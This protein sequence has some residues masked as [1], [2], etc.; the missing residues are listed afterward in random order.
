MPLR[1]KT[2][3]YKG[4]SMA[5][6]FRFGDRLIVEHSSVTD[7][8]PGD[9]VIYRAL[10]HGGKEK[11]L[12]HRVMRMLPKG[13]VARG[14][15]NPFPDR[16]LVTESNLEGRVSHAER[17]GKRIPVRGGWPGLVWAFKGHYFRGI[18][19]WAWGIICHIGRMLY[20]RLRGSGLVAYLW[21]PSVERIRLLTKQGRVVKYVYRNRT[22][23]CYFPQNGRFGC[24][25]PYDL[26]LWHEVKTMGRGAEAKRHPV[27]PLQ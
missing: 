9:V 4:Q 23:A 26:V 21:R 8:H 2:R 20:F 27:P 10:D 1:N 17:G 19:G 16:T 7:I 22:V 11:E 13:M 5:G 15:N 6:T 3:I 25:K 14:D 24:M 18:R 12:V